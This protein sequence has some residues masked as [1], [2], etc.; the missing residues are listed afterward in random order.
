[1]QNEDPSLLQADLENARFT[2]LVA[3]PGRYELAGGA[4]DQRNQEAVPAQHR[5]YRSFKARRDG[6]AQLRLSLGDM[7]VAVV[8]LPFPIPIGT[9]EPAMGNELMWGG[10]GEA[11]SKSKAHLLVSVMGAGKDFEISRLRA[12]RLTA[13]VAALCVLEKALGVFWTASESVIEPGRFVS[14]ARDASEAKPPAGLWISPRFF[15]GSVSEDRLVCRTSGLILF[16][17]RELEC[18]PSSLD[19]GN[20]AGLVLGIARYIIHTGA[21]FADGATIADSGNSIGTIRHQ[22]SRF[23][24]VA[25]TKV[26]KLELVERR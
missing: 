3:L 12:F 8:A 14:V 10:A 13:A 9:L 26:L 16:A 25:E 17:G 11:F 2:A 20:L 24:G 19:A 15:P 23:D 4:V 21:Q 7:I 5:L 1:M 22:A 6:S 18:G